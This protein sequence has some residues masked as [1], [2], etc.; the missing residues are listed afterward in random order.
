[1]KLILLIV[2][3]SGC[4]LMALSLVV[5]LYRHKKTSSRKDLVPG[6]TGQVVTSLHP[7]GTVMVAGELWPAKSA[8]D[9]PISSG[10]RVR[11]VG[12]RD[13]LLLVELQTD[14]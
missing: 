13:H 10:T 1:M 11:V 2:M 7:E 6:Q 14:G 5:V 8:D 4:A 9:N 12:S 3:L